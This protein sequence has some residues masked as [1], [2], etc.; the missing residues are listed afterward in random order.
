LS[1]D[2][3]GR[4]LTVARRAGLGV[5]VIVE[6]FGC[7]EEQPACR[8]QAS[9]DQKGRRISVDAELGLQ[10]PQFVTGDKEAWLAGAELEL[11]PL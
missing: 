4:W 6:Y 2:R 11:K 9:D 10:R 1:F 5:G 7:Q 8:Y 3:P